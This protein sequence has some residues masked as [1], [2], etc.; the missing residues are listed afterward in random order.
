MQTYLFCQLG[1]HK[2]ISVFIHAY[3]VGC[4][5]DHITQLY[6]FPTVQF[7]DTLH[8]RTIST[9]QY[10]A[11]P[12]NFWLHSALQHLYRV[13]QRTVKRGLIAARHRWQ[14]RARDRES[15]TYGAPQWGAAPCPRWGWGSQL[16]SGNTGMFVIYNILILVLLYTSLKLELGITL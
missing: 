3:C 13:V 8:Y 6:I 16:W 4:E 15:L 2:Y 7:T 10:T 14:W 12:H 9:S 5:F 11:P 1:S